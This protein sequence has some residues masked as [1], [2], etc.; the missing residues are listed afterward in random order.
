V[1]EQAGA[2]E[3]TRARGGLLVLT[4]A[5]HTGKT[6]VAHEILHL[7]PPPVALLGVDQVLG[8]VLVRPLGNRWKEIPLAYDLMLPQLEILLREGWFVV[9]ESTFTFVPKT[10]PPELHLDRLEQF[11]QVGANA[12]VF[13]LVVRLA[14]PRD[15][16]LSRVRETAQLSPEVVAKTLDLHEA[17]DL[18]PHVTNINPGYRSPRQLAM[19]ILRR[20]CLD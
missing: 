15:R 16:V 17:A 4:G 7:A 6:S 20:T 1:V 18:P 19:D 5:S 13:V 10:G 2:K 9:L 12:D 3:N 14:L 11:C 8:Q